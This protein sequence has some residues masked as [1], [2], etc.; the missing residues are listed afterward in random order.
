MTLESASTQAPWA[1][2]DLAGA[3][4][5]HYSCTACLTN[6]DICPCAADWGV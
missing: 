3:Y 4:A 1:Q 2:M 5:T 6:K